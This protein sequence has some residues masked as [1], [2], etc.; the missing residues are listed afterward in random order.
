MK[1]FYDLAI[2]NKLGLVPAIVIEDVKILCS[3]NF[4]DD[5]S[6]LINIDGLSHRRLGIDELSNSYEYIDS[7]S[8]KRCV[9]MLIRVNVLSHKIVDGDSYLGVKIFKKRR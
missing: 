2:A 6:E 5:E 9:E 7:D 8:V 3:G 1:K 4:T